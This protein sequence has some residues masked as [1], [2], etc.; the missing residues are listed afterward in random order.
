MPDIYKMKFSGFEN[1][2]LCHISHL[3]PEGWPD[4]VQAFK[5]Y[6]ELDI[7]KPFK[8]LNH[9]EIIGLGS[10]TV[11]GRNAWLAHIIVHKEMRNRGTGSKIVEEL[12]KRVKNENIESIT[13]I[14]TE[15]GA[16]VYIK[17][18]FI[19]VTD[20]MFFT[21]YSDYFTNDFSERIIPYHSQWYKEIIEL[22]KLA[23]GENREGLLRK[24]LPG[25]YLITDKKKVRA[26]YIPGLCEGPVIAN[27]EEPG[28][29]ML[30]FK[31][32]NVENAVVA[33]ENQ[34]ALNFLIQNGFEQIKKTGVR[35][36]IGKHPNWNPVKIFSRIGGNYG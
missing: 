27:S 6:L 36:V 26:F 12:L 7:C 21:R 5:E 34:A 8:M 18:G 3:Q 19:K 9:G 11:F 4:I 1:S 14:S 2:D 20:Y 24:Y 32:R 33:I 29:E 23:T 10:Y 31:Q 13:L 17:A 35:M 15:L 25:S 16:P 30:K 22:D 28:L